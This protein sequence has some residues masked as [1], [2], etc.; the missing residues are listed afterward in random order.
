M[1]KETIFKYEPHGCE[2][3]M[4][5]NCLFTRPSYADDRPSDDEWVEVDREHCIAEGINHYEVYKH[6]GREKDYVN[7]LYDYAYEYETNNI[8]NQIT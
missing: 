2:Y 1:S 8:F 6:F 4:K 3:T 7:F 5:D